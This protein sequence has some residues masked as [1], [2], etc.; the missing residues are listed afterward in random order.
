[1]ASCECLN[2]IFVKEESFHASQFPQKPVQIFLSAYT[3]TQPEQ[4]FIFIYF[5]IVTVKI[6]A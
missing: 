1:M 4:V 2:I 5:F 3:H 6:C